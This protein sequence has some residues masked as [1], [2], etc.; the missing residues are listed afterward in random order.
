MQFPHV[1]YDLNPTGQTFQFGRTCWIPSMH[2]NVSIENNHIEL[3]ISTSK[4][5]QYHN[6]ANIIL[7]KNNTKFCPYRATIKYIESCRRLKGPFFQFEDGK[8]LTAKALNSMIHAALPPTN[9]GTFFSHSFRIG[10]AT[11]A[12]K[13]G[14][15]RYVIQELGRWKS[16][17]FTQYIRFNKK[18]FLKLSQGLAAP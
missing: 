17:C 9:K 18:M 16:T 15:P 10:S 5:D 12:A 4:T 7:A 1:T 2:Q 13:N 6:G 11:T 8:Y 3:Y 14:Y